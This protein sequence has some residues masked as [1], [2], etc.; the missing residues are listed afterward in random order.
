MRRVYRRIEQ[1][2]VTVPVALLR[3]DGVSLKAK[4]LYAAL[5]TCS[6]G[7]ALATLVGCSTDGRDSFDAALEELVKAGWIDVEKSDYHLVSKSA[8]NP[9]FSS[10]KPAEHPHKSPEIPLREIRKNH[11]RSSG[12]SAILKK[13]NPFKESEVLVLSL[14]QKEA[15]SDRKSSL[16]VPPPEPPPTEIVMSDDPG[17][18]PE[19]DDK[20]RTLRTSLVNTYAKMVAHFQEEEAANVDVRYYFEQVMDWSDTGGKRNK[21]VKRTSRGW[22]A[23]M[24]TFMRRDNTAGKLKMIG[25]PDMSKFFQH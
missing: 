24:R 7:E 2:S 9:P 12:K 21:P 25:G 23:T 18:F 6:D 22:I 13:E 17:L 10:V 16:A 4:G 8:G 3:D 19:L 15:N 20:E 14:E 11:G 5:L 1:G